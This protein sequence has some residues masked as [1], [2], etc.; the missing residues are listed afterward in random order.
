MLRG[1]ELGK[2]AA[3]EGIYKVPTGDVEEIPLEDR[4]FAAL[5]LKLDLLNSVNNDFFPEGEINRGS[6]A[7]AVVNYMR[8]FSR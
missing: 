7:A 5:A 4:G 3:L 2:I 8:A 1:L 6:A